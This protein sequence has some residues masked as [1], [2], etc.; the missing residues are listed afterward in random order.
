MKRLFTLLTLACLSTLLFAQRGTYENPD[1]VLKDLQL[2]QKT[3]SF[4]TQN[5][6]SDGF[7]LLKP[8]Y[9]RGKMWV[10][11]SIL[12]YKANGS[13]WYLT[14]RFN[15]LLRDEYG[16]MTI[17]R[18]A[19]LNPSTDVWENQDTIT[20]SYKGPGDLLT[21]TEKSWNPHTQQ[22]A[23]TSYYY[24]IDENGQWSTTFRRI[25]DFNSNTLILGYKDYVTLDENGNHSAKTKYDWNTTINGW[26]PEEKWTYTYDDSGNRTQTLDQIWDVTTENWDNKYLTTFTYDESGNLEEMLT[27]SWDRTSEQWKN[28]AQ[29]FYSHDG[30]GNLT[31]RIDQ[32]WSSVTNDWINDSKY[33]STYDDSGKKLTWLFQSWLSE[34]EDWGNVWQWFFSYD[35]QGNPTQNV[36]QRWNFD[37]GEWENEVQ[38][39]IS[40]DDSGNWIQQ[41][42]Q[43][44][45]TDAGKWENTGQSLSSYDE[46]GNL[47]EEVFQMWNPQ[48]EEWGNVLKSVYYWSEFDASDISGINNLNELSVKIYP[49]PVTDNITL[50]RDGSSGLMNVSLLTVTGRLIK[51]AVLTGQKSSMDL[52]GLSKGTYILHIETDKGTYS[53]KIVKL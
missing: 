2:D 43:N 33:S 3:E 18:S 41:L 21:Y 47:T 6:T 26:Y 42:Q 37:T 12:N 30:N 32:L 40:Y 14:G 46:Q 53:T 49:N 20:A 38:F 7:K 1:K 4:A 16:N 19:F 50:E 5:E 8:N 27:Q 23:D 36:K 9:T 25:W 35:E 11:D 13:E 48:T 44:W 24:E 52:S 51:T 31:E 10:N 28:N 29:T 45:N 39:F 15:V 34:S 22:W 17:A